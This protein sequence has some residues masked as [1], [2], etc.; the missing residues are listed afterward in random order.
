MTFLG[1]LISTYGVTVDPTKTDKIA[2]WPEPL[3]QRD[4]QQF[5]GL[6]NYYRRFIKDFATIAKPLHHHTEKTIVFKWAEQCHAAFL[7]LK[8][9]LISPP[10]LAFPDHSKPYILD[11]DASD[12]G[13]GGVLSQEQYDGLERVI[14]YGSRDHCPKLKKLLCYEA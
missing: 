3:Y 10:V 5:L 2:T 11:S 6:A 1:H 7:S 8:Q 12:G 4:I 14:A 13:I 9:M